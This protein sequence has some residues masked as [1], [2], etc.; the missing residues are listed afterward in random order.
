MVDKCFVTK[1]RPIPCFFLVSTTLAFLEC[2]VVEILCNTLTY[3]VPWHTFGS[4]PCFFI[5]SHLAAFRSDDIPF[6]ECT[7]V[8][9]CTHMNNV[10]NT[11]FHSF[12]YISTLQCW[13][14]ELCLSQIKKPNSFWKALT[15]PQAVLTRSPG[16]QGKYKQTNKRPCGFAIREERKL[17]LEPG[18]FSAV[19]PG[20]QGSHQLWRAQPTQVWRA[21][22]TRHLK[23]RESIAM[24]TKYFS[25][26][27]PGRSLTA[28][29]FRL[30][31]SF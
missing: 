20:S 14:M 1:P 15:S 17:K 24:A 9:V 30:R 26:K 10:V 3:S 27:W 19:A 29:T 25:V 2:H 21:A 11:C 28:V 7:T 4:L 23:K 6:Y 31:N 13:G 16:Q 18:H 12:I 8:N 5:I 22:R